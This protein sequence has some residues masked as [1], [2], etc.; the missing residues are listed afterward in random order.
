[1]GPSEGAGT[2]YAYGRVELLDKV[3]WSYVARAIKSVFSYP[4]Y[5]F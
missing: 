2:G 4:F 5:I 3:S 1:M